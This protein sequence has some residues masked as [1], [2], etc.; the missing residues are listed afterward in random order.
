MGDVARL[1]GCSQ[2]TVSLVLNEIPN[3]RIAEDT[4]RRVREAA[5]EIGYRMPWAH[6]RPV[7]AMREIGFVVD[8]LATSP[9]AVVSIDGA[10]E[11]ARQEDHLLLIAATLSDAEIE[12]STLASLLARPID[13]L[14]YASIMTRRIEPPQLPRHV[15]TVLL[16]CYT[17]D[18][19]FPAVVPGELAGGQSATQRLVRAGHRRIA[20]VTGEMWMEAA[21]DRL[22]GYRRALATADLP[23][24]P[25][26]VCEGN[27]EYGSGHDAAR[28]LMGLP[29]PPTA[30]FFANDRMAVGGYALL[31]ERGLRIPED[32]SVIG[33]D[34]QAVC[35]ELT[36]ALTT[37]VLPHREMGQWAVERLLH[38]AGRPHGGRHAIVKLDCPLVER[39]SVG[40]PR[41]RG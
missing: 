24:D 19:S 30:I 36:P 31:R 34:D 39:D 16:N 35:Q 6:A 20:H 13:G 15:P 33:Y 10:H 1:A 14:I 40:P 3:V 28:R 23:F 8:R 25:D 32:V 12:R 41:G 5:Q 4:R 29:D 2:S 7:G 37:M 26:L 11:A 18:R 9:E 21:Q 38:Q 22:R 17:D 27:W